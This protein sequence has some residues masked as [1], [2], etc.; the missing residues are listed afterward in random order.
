M[1]GASSQLALR[2]YPRIAAE[3]GG[4]EEGKEEEGLIQNGV[5]GGKWC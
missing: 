2:V 3:E 5:G 4:R 1:E